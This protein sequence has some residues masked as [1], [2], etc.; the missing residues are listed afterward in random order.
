M[1]AAT[2]VFSLLLV[3]PQ[4]T[5][6]EPS[7]VHAAATDDGEVVQV[8]KTEEDL[9]EMG[10]MERRAAFSLNDDLHPSIED[11]LLPFF[12]G[13]LCSTIGGPLWMPLLFLDDKP[14][15]YFDEALLSWLVWAIPLW[16]G[17]AIVWIPY[18]GWAFSLLYCPAALI[19]GFYLMPVNVA[20]AWDRAAKV[21]GM[22]E[23]GSKKRKKKSSAVLPPREDALA[24]VDPAMAY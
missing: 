21:Y 14:N 6:S 15:E 1:F 11:D 9:E 2:V 16:A 20:N 8:Q 4:A 7:A 12:L 24:L 5:A 22:E 17:V 10:F 19:I 23:R 18:I 13:G 3:S